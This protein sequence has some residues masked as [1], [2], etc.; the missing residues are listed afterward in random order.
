L[1]GKLKIGGIVDSSTVDYIGKLC[2]VVYLCGCPFRCGWCQNKEL[3][4]ERNCSIVDIED[5]INFLN[6]NFVIDAVCVTGGE[7]LMQKNVIELLRRMR[8]ETELLI[9]ID[10][11]L[12]FPDRLKTALKFLDFVSVDVKSP[13]DRRYDKLVGINCNIDR[14]QESLEI[15]KKW[16]MPKEARTTIVPNLVDSNDIRD[17]AKIVR[18]VEFDYYTL[19]QFRPS[20]TLDEKF[21]ELETLK[22]EDMIKLGRIAKKFL[23][24]TRV[25]I[26]TQ[27]NGFEEIEF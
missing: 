17:I 21:E 16:K 3:V 20:N 15:L 18:N 9:K 23:P 12:Y 6:E 27:E 10:T 24:K 1:Q 2:A 11:N 8:N 14:I 5:I 22:R 25:R 13:L 4:L 7:P 26:V 19:Q